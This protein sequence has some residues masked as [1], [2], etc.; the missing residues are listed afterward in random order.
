MLASDKLVSFLMKLT[1]NNLLV[2]ALVHNDIA[3][4]AVAI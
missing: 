1:F 3:A 4:V 2:H